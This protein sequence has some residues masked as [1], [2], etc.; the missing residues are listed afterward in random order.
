MVHETRGETKR[1]DSILPLSNNQSNS[2][3]SIQAEPLIEE[4]SKYH[5]KTRLNYSQHIKIDQYELN[6]IIYI[7]RSYIYLS[8]YLQF[9]IML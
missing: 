5:A 1:N 3:S 9:M 7:C 6:V 2:N 4:K 8:Q